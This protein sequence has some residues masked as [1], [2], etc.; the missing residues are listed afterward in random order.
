MV[1]YDIIDLCLGRG[2][3]IAVHTKFEILTVQPIEL[4]SRKMGRVAAPTACK[5]A[6][7]VLLDAH[8]PLTPPPTAAIFGS[9][10]V[11]RG[12]DRPRRPSAGR[13]RAQSFFSRAL[14]A[15]AAEGVECYSSLHRANTG[16][17]SAALSIA[18]A[19][20]SVNDLGGCAPAPAGPQLRHQDRLTAIFPVQRCHGS[21]QVAG[22]FSVGRATTASSDGPD[23]LGM[24]ARRLGAPAAAAWSDAARVRGCGGAEKGA[25]KRPQL[26]ATV[27]GLV[28]LPGRPWE[29][30]T[31]GS[32]RPQS[33]LNLPAMSRDKTWVGVPSAV[34]SACRGRSRHVDRG[35]ARAGCCG[36]AGGGGGG[37]GASCC[38]GPAARAG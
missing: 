2:E 19:P 5:A 28:S 8:P 6:L 10:R 34:P 38:G 9:F 7:P 11:H 12:A 26:R 16:S 33:I 36:R 31:G 20:P 32:D 17:L 14:A 24:M 23:W 4:C 15:A 22:P 13:E 3:G 1:P 37:G 27:P 29:A 18:P 21:A 25:V 35:I 30:T